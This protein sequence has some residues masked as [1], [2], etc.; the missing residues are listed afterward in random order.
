[1]VQ[2]PRTRIYTVDRLEFNDS[3]SYES[4]FTANSEGKF[5]FDANSAMFDTTAD[6]SSN[7]EIIEGTDL[8]VN[9]AAVA[10]QQRPMSILKGRRRKSFKS[11]EMPAGSIAKMM[12]NEQFQVVHPKT[13]KI[14]GSMTYASKQANIEYQAN[15]AA[16][17]YSRC[18]CLVPS[19]EPLGNAHYRVNLHHNRGFG[20]IS[21]L[22]INTVV[23][24]E[25]DID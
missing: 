22:R 6:D 15:V 18:D 23:E 4:D 10:K 5:Q 17:D 20:P 24:A 2:S 19:E 11:S 21:K 7:R 16:I 3:D 13:K 14:A 12:A 25:T 9:A 1:M 8:N